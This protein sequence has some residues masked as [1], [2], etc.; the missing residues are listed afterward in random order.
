M[1]KKCTCK[2]QYQDKKYGINN[3]VHNICAKDKESVRYRCTVCG[4][5]K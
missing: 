4:S 5:I 1:I 2:H 3:R